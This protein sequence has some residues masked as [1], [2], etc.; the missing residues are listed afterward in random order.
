MRK[1]T[2]EKDERV[3]YLRYYDD[4]I[5]FLSCAEKVLRGQKKGTFNGM[6]CASLSEGNE[7]WSGTNDLPQAIKLAF[8]GWPEGREQVREAQRRMQIEKL[9]PQSQRIVR[10]VDLAGDEPDVDLFLQG[11]PEHMVTLHEAIRPQYGKVMRFIL[12]RTAN[13]G[14]SSDRI[15]RRG[16]AL[17]TAMETL[18]ILGF[19]VEM[20]V[21]FACER[22][23]YQLEQYMPI[24]HAGDPI[25]LDTLAFMFLHPAVLRRLCFAANECEPTEIRDQFGFVDHGGYGS[26]C[27]PHFLPKCDLFH[28][29]DEGLLSSDDQ[30]IPMVLK[31]L[32][33]AGI[34]MP[35]AA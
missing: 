33:Q 10:Q 20:M 13:A 31:I 7:S 24:L 12:N 35:E 21:M 23:I 6:S 29:W 28:N 14:V 34:K 9:P 8:Q 27:R 26:S 19:T 3:Y 16:V 17:L 30:I 15:V 22:G 1:E 32:D 5:D 2:K 4:W 11:E 25:N 18:I